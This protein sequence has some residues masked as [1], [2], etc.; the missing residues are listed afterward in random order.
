M[1]TAHE[2]HQVP[3]HSIRISSTFCSSHHILK[4]EDMN[5]GHGYAKYYTQY[6]GQLILEKMNTEKDI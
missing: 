4:H 6:T 5:I 2:L 3:Q 1:H